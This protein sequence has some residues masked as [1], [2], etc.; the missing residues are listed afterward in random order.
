[1]LAGALDGVCLEG[2]AFRLTAKDTPE[3]GKITVG[4]IDI[5]STSF[6]SRLWFNGM[7]PSALLP[8]SASGLALS[9]ACLDGVSPSLVEERSEQRG[10][11]GFGVCVLRAFAVGG[12]TTT[13][14]TCHTS[15]FGFFK[16]KEGL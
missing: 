8:T 16:F 3:K 10:V 6:F 2:S 11:I 15:R 9:K 7:H 14:G 5:Y 12:S 4:L 13:A 1:L